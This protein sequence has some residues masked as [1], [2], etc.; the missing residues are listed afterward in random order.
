MR[1]IK[2]YTVKI[3]KEENKPILNF[4][5]NEVDYSSSE[6]ALKIAKNV[7]EKYNKKGYSYCIF[8]E[9]IKVAKMVLNKNHKRVQNEIYKG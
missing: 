3:F 6:E 9:T 1:E 8:E 4:M 5:Y 7:A 2:N